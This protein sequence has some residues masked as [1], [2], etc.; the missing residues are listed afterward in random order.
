MTEQV[1][2]ASSDPA[3]MVEWLRRAVG[4]SGRKSRLF[5]AGCYRRVWALL[6]DESRAAVETA[7]RYAE[8]AAT[9]GELA[10]VARGAT[11]P[12]RSAVARRLGRSGDV[13]ARAAAELAG[14]AAYARVFAAIAG[15]GTSDLRSV[16]DELGIPVEVACDGRDAY[17]WVEGRE[18]EVQAALLRDLFGPLP[19]RRVVVAQPWRNTTVLALARTIYSERAFDR[20]PILAD[21]LEEAGCDD[22]AV[23]AHCRGDG[24][25]VRGCWVLDLILGRE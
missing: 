6:S 13:A 11:G 8:G 18:R 17:L 20:M 1:W 25:H 14:S 5:A 21:A 4:M 9:V 12:V 19:F 23:L 10:G 24:P 3:A 16:A 15:R 2:L 22:E 7:E